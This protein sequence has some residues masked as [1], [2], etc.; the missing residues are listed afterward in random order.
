MES[1]P[2]SASWRHIWLTRQLQNTIKTNRCNEVPKRLSR[3][4]P[5]RLK[6][7]EKTSSTDY[8][9]QYTTLN[10]DHSELKFKPKSKQH[11]KD[12]MFELRSQY[13]MRPSNIRSFLKT[14]EQFKDEPTPTIRHI[15]YVFDKSN[16]TVIMPTLTLGELYEW[17]VA[18]SKVPSP[19]EIDQVFNVANVANA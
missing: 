7:F 8:S 11:V 10:H 16:K 17:C 2:Q 1:P 13:Q 6:V 12:K 14:E 9:V 5:V 4:C 19:S 3:L 18:M 15:R